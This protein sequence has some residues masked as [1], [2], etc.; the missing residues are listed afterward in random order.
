MFPLPTDVTPS[1]TPSPTRAPGSS[2]SPSPGAAADAA[3]AAHEKKVDAAAA[4]FGTLGGL[5]LVSAGIVFFLPSAGFMVGR[6]LVVPA[7]YIKSA[8]GATWRGVSVV[9]RGVGG[10]ISGA[11][12]GAVSSTRSGGGVSP[13]FAAPSSEG[14]SL[15]R[16]APK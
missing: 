16:P 7:D 8:A 13:A 15:L 2:P 14:T 1:G 4:V 9:G 11:Y 3:A 12:S 10:A 5:A 6:T